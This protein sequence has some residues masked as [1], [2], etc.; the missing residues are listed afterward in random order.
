MNLN[1]YLCHFL[2]LL[3]NYCFLFV[4][5]CFLFPLFPITYSFPLSNFNLFFL[6]TFIAPKLSL[7]L[8]LLFI[9][10][11][12]RIYIFIFTFSS[13]TIFYLL[14]YPSPISSP[15]PFLNILHSSFYTF[16]SFPLLSSHHTCFIYQWLFF[17]FPSFFFFLSFL[18]VGSS[19]PHTTS[20]H[21]PSPKLTAN[22]KKE[23]EMIWLFISTSSI[24]TTV[25]G[26]KNGSDS[27]QP[28]INSNKPFVSFLFFTPLTF[29]N[30]L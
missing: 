28:S 11:L 22:K 6:L 13:L 23:K 9:F 18:Y 14:I 4:L 17:S 12:F 16:I 29:P 21:Q 19:L 25:R 20:C 8:I 7:E 15:F 3:I 24:K 27:L 2:L 26:E 1:T 30:E 10:P 5:C